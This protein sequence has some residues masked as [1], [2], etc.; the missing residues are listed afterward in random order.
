MYLRCSTKWGQ[1]LLG[2]QKR[3]WTGGE[4]E[5]KEEEKEKKKRISSIQT[6]DHSSTR[7]N[8]EEKERAE[9]KTEKSTNYSTIFCHEL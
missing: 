5:A 2:K 1:N 9:Q 4:T 3:H 8:L 6:S 7:I